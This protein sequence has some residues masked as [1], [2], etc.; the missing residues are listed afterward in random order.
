MD[1]VVAFVLFEIITLLGQSS[2][3]GHGGQLGRAIGRAIGVTIAL[4]VFAFL[5]TIYVLRPALTHPRST[6][7]LKRTK[8]LG[9]PFTLLLVALGMVA[10]SGYAGAS[11]LY[12]I[13][14]AGLMFAYIS[15]TKDVDAPS[16]TQLP[17]RLPPLTRSL[18]Y[19]ASRRLASSLPSISTV[20]PT[21]TPILDFANSYNTYLSKPVDY[22]LLPMFFGSIGYSIPFLSLW[23]GRIDWRGVVYAVLDVPGQGDLWGLIFP[24]PRGSNR[25]PGGGRWEWRDRIVPAM[26][27]GRRWSLEGKSGCC[28]WAPNAARGESGKEG[29]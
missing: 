27:W 8:G 23:R 5:L 19:P 7:R 21:P 24:T 2:G 15:E 25:R 13:C 20:P 28:E 18:T 6:Y 12:G 11:P 3:Q 22:L 26:Y 29:Y 9:T 16:L 1:D 4:A 14:L 17:Q 10:A